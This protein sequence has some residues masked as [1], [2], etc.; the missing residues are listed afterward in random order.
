[1]LYQSV[2]FTKGIWGLAELKMQPGNPAAQ[3]RRYLILYRNDFRPSNMLLCF[4]VGL[5]VVS[6]GSSHGCSDQSPSHVRDHSAQLRST[7][8]FQQQTLEA[9]IVDG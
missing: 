5:A 2:K 3:V 6:E 4:L 8:P 9:Q 1:M 7:K